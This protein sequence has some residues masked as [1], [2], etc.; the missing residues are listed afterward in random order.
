MYI[1][2]ILT[3]FGV[4]MNEIFVKANCPEYKI[5]M[6]FHKAALEYVNRIDSSKSKDGI[7]WEYALEHI[8]KE[9]F[10]KY[11]LT[12]PAAANGCT[13]ETYI[14]IESGS[15][16]VPPK[17]V[18]LMEAASHMTAYLMENLDAEFWQQNPA[19]VQQKITDFALI[20]APRFV[21]QNLFH[22]D[23]FVDKALA[24]T[25]PDFWEVLEEEIDPDE[26]GV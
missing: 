20:W 12:I 21:D 3:H 8:P 10:G 26:Y 4:P 9:L 14:D 18:R 16:L 13:V 11:G 17:E 2:I 5:K 1:L 19:G 22:I 15:F 6:N 24:N 7:T 23:E 25:A